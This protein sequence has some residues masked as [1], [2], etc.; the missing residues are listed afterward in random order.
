MQTGM[1]AAQAFAI[2]SHTA[3]AHLPLTCNFP[4]KQK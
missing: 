2:A 1:P 3:N 4:E